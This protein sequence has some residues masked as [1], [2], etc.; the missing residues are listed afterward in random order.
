MFADVSRGDGNEGANRLVLGFQQMRRC[1][2]LGAPPQDAGW[3]TARRRRRRW[4]QAIHKL[5]IKPED[6]TSKQTR[7]LLTKPQFEQRRSHKT[8]RSGKKKQIKL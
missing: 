5:S 7:V 2:D 1:Q 4:R 3:K 6:L 8:P